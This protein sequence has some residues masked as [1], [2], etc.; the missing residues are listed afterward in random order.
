MSAYFLSSKGWFVVLATLS[1]VTDMSFADD[2]DDAINFSASTAVSGRT[3]RYRA[4]RNGNITTVADWVTT[5]TMMTTAA[6]TVVTT[7]AQ[8]ASESHRWPPTTAVA[9]LDNRRLDNNARC[10]N[11]PDNLT[12]CR[13]LLGYRQ[14]RT[15]DLLRLVVGDSS[16][17][18]TQGFVAG[19][20]EALL[21]PSVASNVRDRPET[22][23]A[24][25][26]C[27][28]S[29]GLF[30]CSL[31]SPVCLERPVWPCRSLCLRVRRDCSG[32]VPWPE[33]IDCDRLPTDDQLCIGRDASSDNDTSIASLAAAYVGMRQSAKTATKTVTAAAA[34][35]KHPANVSNRVGTAEAGGQTPNIG[36]G[37]CALHCFGS[38]LNDFETWRRRNLRS[39]L[40]TSFNAQTRAYQIV[41]F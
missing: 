28:P 30:V 8:S 18:T 29:A 34:A 5:T 32:A 6:A 37:W 20:V 17:S 2:G 4:S 39:T 22:G 35:T 16:P 7:A 38:N 9:E 3:R 21:N 19:W 41:L 27:S 10:V 40:F 36:N 1:V 12:A 14:M 15:P 11:I 23:S 13:S 24:L 26:A 25:P 31:L 33:S